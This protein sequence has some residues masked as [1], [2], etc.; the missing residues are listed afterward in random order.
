MRSVKCKCYALS[1]RQV[2]RT[3]ES[4]FGFYKRLSNLFPFS[5]DFA[6]IEEVLTAKNRTS[7]FT[8]QGT[9]CGMLLCLVKIHFLPEG[10]WSDLSLSVSSEI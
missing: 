1:R 6:N 3:T 10:F 2:L 4:T 8:G 7:N 5:R 9:E